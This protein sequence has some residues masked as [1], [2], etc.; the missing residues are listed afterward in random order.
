MLSPIQTILRA[1]FG[2]RLPHFRKCWRFPTYRSRM[3]FSSL[4]LFFPLFL[5]RR[6]IFYF[7]SFDFLK[8]NLF[9]RNEYSY[10]HCCCDCGWIYLCLT[11]YILVNMCLSLLTIFFV[12]FKI[13]DSLLVLHLGGVSIKGELVFRHTTLLFV[14]TKRGRK[15]SKLRNLKW[16]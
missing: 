4:S 8:V 6:V 14:L 1:L 13:H 15:I 3:S 16:K 11:K 10:L 7:L 12:G 2:G 5:S 9:T